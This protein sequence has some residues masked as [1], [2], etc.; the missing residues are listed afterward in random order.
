[1]LPKKDTTFTKVTKA[2]AEAKLIIVTISFIIASITGAYTI[3]SEYFVTRVYADSLLKK[4]KD[5]L[6]ELKI[7]T[8]TNRKILTEMQMIRLEAKI[9][10]GETL[11][12]TEQRVY[13]Q[14]K[15]SYEK[16]NK[17]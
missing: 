1:M 2:V 13:E 17:I 11:T 14:L 12:P 9:G 7:Q 8:K 6:K 5:D 15:K 16:I 10:R 4:V 3:A